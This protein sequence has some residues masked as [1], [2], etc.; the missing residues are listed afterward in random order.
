MSGSLS[1]AYEGL[2]GAMTRLVAVH[3]EMV[4]N[5]HRAREVAEEV[6][7]DPAQRRSRGGGRSAGA[8]ILGAILGFNPFGD[9]GGAASGSQGSSRFGE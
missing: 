5:C 6:I 9:F 1:A 3:R 7:G 2:A 4:E 8:A